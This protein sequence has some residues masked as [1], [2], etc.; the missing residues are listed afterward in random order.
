MRSS[1]SLKIV[2]H[3]ERASPDETGTSVSKD[4]SGLMNSI[5]SSIVQPLKDF[6][7]V[8][9]CFHCGERLKERE[10]RIC[11]K[12]WNSLTTVRESDYTY[13][14][15]KERF[16]DGGV[17][18]DFVTLYYFEKGTLLQDIAHSLKYEEVTTFGF[19]LGVKLGE[20]VR[21]M[22]IDCIV[23]VP[24]NKRKER[25][26]GY[27]QSDFIAKGISSVI[28]V[29][30]FT[31]LLHR[32]KYTTTQTHLNARE[33]KENISDAFAV[34]RKENIADKTILIVDDII[35]TGATI[36]ESAITL[37]NGGAIKIIAGSVGLAKLG[38]D[39]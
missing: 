10:H 1:D 7:F 37:K 2:R 38:E 17:I 22:E 39:S 16:R 15:L 21:G 26:R 34:N 33:R 4:D 5:H 36:Q 19:E 30:F 24:L 8:S 20:R 32:V 11:K 9:S 25:E 14:V 6:L 12:C 13:N 35:T 18:D 28:N 31:D 3:P 29:P 27:N 23:P